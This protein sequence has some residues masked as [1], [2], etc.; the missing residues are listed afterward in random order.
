MRVLIVGCGYIGAALG[1]ELVRR[2]HE[3]VG[4]RR[5]D[6]QDSELHAA[7]IRP[8][9]AD[10]T[11]AAD[12]RV[13][14]DPFDWIVNCISTGGGRAEDY[15]RV[16]LAGMRNLLAWLAHRPPRRL[17]Y[18]SSTSVYGQTDGS[19]VDEQS[20]AE[21]N[22]ETGQILLETERAL[23]EA[24]QEGNWPAV[25]L[26]L[27]AIYGPGRGYW[28][29]RALRGEWSAD[30]NAGRYLNQ[31]HRDDVVGCIEAALQ[32]GATGSIYNATDD[33]PVRQ[34]DLLRWLSGRRGRAAS[35]EKSAGGG[36]A[37]LRGTSHKR[38]SN[39]KLKE[40]LGYRFEFPTFREGYQAE[41]G[42]I[43]PQDCI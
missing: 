37:S 27:S 17:V 25:V 43:R 38:V 12:L 26:R 39:R 3:V 5:G 7:G 32:R 21:P 2:G 15:R 18:T 1:S 20:P 8:V 11:R 42:R 40:E 35:R 19:E 33:E 30:T 28:L 31:I 6:S 14:S 16:Y 22:S 34:S 24:A 41:L 13:L 9:H 29:Q 23:L 10:I 4:L 36:G